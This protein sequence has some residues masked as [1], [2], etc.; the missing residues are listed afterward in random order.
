MSDLNEKFKTE[1]EALAFAQYLRQLNHEAHVLELPRSGE[2]AVFDGPD[3][4][5]QP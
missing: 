3:P 5:L 1:R 2:W 4:E